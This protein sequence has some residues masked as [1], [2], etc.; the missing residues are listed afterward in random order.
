[1]QELNATARRRRI[2]TASLMGIIWSTTASAQMESL[3]RN[4]TWVQTAL[5][6]ACVLIFTCLIIFVGVQI[7][8]RHA[9]LMDLWHIILGASLAGGAVGIA[10]LLVK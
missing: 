8:A 3:N 7:A 9:K 4:L 10:A 2:L 1:M 6:A 5:T